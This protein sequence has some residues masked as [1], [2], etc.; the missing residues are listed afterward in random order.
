LVSSI[1]ELPCQACA[2]DYT[3]TH[4]DQHVIGLVDIPVHASGAP[5][6]FAGDVVDITPVGISVGSTPQGG[7]VS[8][9]Y[10]REVNAVLRNHVLVVGNPVAVLDS[11]P[12]RE[13]P[14]E[15]SRSSTIFEI[16]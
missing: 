14:P 4:G 13:Q 5:Q 11:P 10:N 9:G 12:R 2:L 7:F 15:I 16:A 3:D 6:T 1:L 8:I